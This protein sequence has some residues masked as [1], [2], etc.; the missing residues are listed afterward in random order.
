MHGSSPT[1]V[2]AVGAAGTILHYN[3]TRWARVRAPDDGRY[4]DVAVRDDLVLIVRD[5]LGVASSRG[6]VALV[7]R[8]DW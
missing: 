6:L 5:T 1:D 3:G 2:W 8:R 7:R 4:L